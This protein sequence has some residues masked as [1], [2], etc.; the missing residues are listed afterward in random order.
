MSDP[1][2][3]AVA[4]NLQLLVV[5]TS[6]NR[7][8][9]WTQVPDPPA[10]TTEAATNVE[11]TSATLNAKVNPYGLAT[12]YRFEYDTTAYKAGEAGHGTSIPVPDESIGSGYTEVSVNKAISGLQAKTKY[13]FRVVAT[14]ASGTTVAPQKTFTTP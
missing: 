1:T 11:S 14:N 4:G 8:Q 3:I 10:A 9:H 5:D 7:V 12:T 13:Y 2:G 6:N